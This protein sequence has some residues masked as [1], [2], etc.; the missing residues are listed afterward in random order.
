MAP[1]SLLERKK[2]GQEHG[3]GNGVARE[4]RPSRPARRPQILSCGRVAGRV[5]PSAGG[6]ADPAVPLPRACVR[7]PCL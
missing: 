6:A 2:N 7:R 1:P 3:R 5:A 4:L